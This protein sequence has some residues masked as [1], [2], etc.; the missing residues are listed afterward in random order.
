M[1]TLKLISPRTQRNIRTNLWLPVAFPP[2]GGMKSTTSPTP[3]SL[4]NRVMR[5]AVSGK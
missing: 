4:R 1:S 5:T 3:A 2:A